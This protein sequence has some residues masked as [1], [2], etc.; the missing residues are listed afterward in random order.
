MKLKLIIAFLFL[1]FTNNFSQSSPVQQKE[2]NLD[3]ARG[4]VWY[5][6]FPERFADGDTTNEPTT[7]K[8][9]IHSRRKINDWKVKRWTSDWYEQDKWEK[10]AGGKFRNHLFDRRYGGDL[11]G[12]IDHLDYLKDLGVGSIYINPIFDAVSL[13]KYDG[14]SY[15]HIDINFGPDPEGD[16]KLIDSETPE[17]PSTWKWTSAD[18]LFLKLISEVHRRGM[19][20]IIDGV[21]NHVGTQ[22][23][24]FK[25]LE[26]KQQNSKYK[27]WF[28]IKSFDNPLTKKNEFD[29]K[30][31]WNV[32]SLPQFNRTENDLIAG[33]KQYIFN[34]TQRWMDPNNDGVGEDGIDGWRLDVARD[35]PMGFWKDWS[36]LVRSIN[37]HAIIIGELWELS[38]DFISENKVFDGLMNYNFAYA[39]KGL[40][41]DRKN[42]I[43]V[44]EF[45]NKL[46]EIDSTYPKENLDLLQNLMDSH[47][48]ERLS[49]MIV[50]PDRK[51]DND[52]NEE[53]KNYNPGKPSKA[54]YEIQKMV[55]AFQMTYKG[56][57]MIYYG[58]EVGMWGADDPHDR[59]PMVWDNLKYDD[60]II[61]AKSGFK[62]GFG[63][64]SVEQ[65]KDLLNFYKSLTTIRNENA[66]IQKGNLK[67][68]YSNDVKKSFAFEREYG[69]EKIIV[70]FNLGNEEDQFGLSLDNNKYTYTELMSSEEGTLYSSENERVN[71]KIDIAPGSFKI[72]KLYKL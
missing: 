64:Y 60:Q 37:D 55:A 36:K 67:F 47:D 3:W 69:N 56:A 44:S 9:L 34:A 6:I 33:P 23:W 42:Q 28:E 68:F 8:V 38:P 30:G 27:D 54:D 66:A 41:I 12:I 14:S 32:K 22:F 20:I 58:D 62:K 57:P 43:K 29:Y 35:V 24:A 70:V 1:I 59:Q 18:S 51:Y 21:F 5:Q 25:D 2:K 46:N 40:F 13:H 52:G 53:N 26:K 50:N 71:F 61:T 48:T 15:H 72:Y 49:S 19:H 16:K 4:I 10:E 7:D 45:I 11:Q 31:W 39:V 65:N 17:N 63:K